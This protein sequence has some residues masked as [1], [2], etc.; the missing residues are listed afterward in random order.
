MKD[1]EKKLSGEIKIT[2]IEFL[3]LISSW[4]RSED[5]KTDDEIYLKK[6]E[7]KECY[8]LDKLDISEVE[9]YKHV[10]VHSLYNGPD[11][12]HLILNNHASGVRTIIQDYCIKEKEEPELNNDLNL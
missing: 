9:S 6:C 3:N 5:F 10:F 12:T 11:L 2:R 4:G 1:L 7:P 8:P